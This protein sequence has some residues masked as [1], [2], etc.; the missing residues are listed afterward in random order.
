MNSAIFTLMRKHPQILFLEK[1]VSHIKA[2]KM[3]EQK[4]VFLNKIPFIFLSLSTFL[5]IK[6]SLT[7][8]NPI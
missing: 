8:F 3:T 5:I 7:R 6:M 2:K 1:F 4:P